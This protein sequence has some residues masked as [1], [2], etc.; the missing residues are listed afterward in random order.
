MRAKHV[1]TTSAEA[2]RA[3]VPL[4]GHPSLGTNATMRSGPPLPP[5][6]FMGSATT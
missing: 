6:I 4:P 1:S 2:I 5:S 3:I